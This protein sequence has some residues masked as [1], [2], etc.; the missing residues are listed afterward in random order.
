VAFHGKSVLVAAFA[1]VAGVGV[2]PDAEPA[3]RQFDRG[4]AVGELPRS[5]SAP[6]MRAHLLALQRIADR[7]GGTRAAGTAGYRASVRYVRDRLRA[8]GYR[9]RVVDFP[10]VEY[11][12]LRERVLQIS[13]TS[14]VLRA[15]AIDYSP[16]TPRGGLRGRVVPITRDGCDPTDFQGV[17]GSVALAQR[18]TCFISVKARNAAA[19]GARALIV[20]SA[21]PGPLDA[22]L[23]DPRA[24]SIPVAAVHAA[25]AKRL[26][27]G[28]NAVVRLEITTRR[29]QSTSQ[30]VIAETDSSARR[31]LLVGAHLDSVV[32][33][34][35]INDNGTGVAALLEIARLVRRIAPELSVR[36]GFWGAEEFGLFGSRAYAARVDARELVGYLNLDMLGSRSRELAV[37][38]NGP[39]TE[40]LLEYVRAAGVRATTIDLE[41]RSDHFAF[42]QIGVPT[43]GVM[44]G[45]DRCYHA[46]CDRLGRVDL[47]TLK[48]LA[49]AVA[50]ATASFAPAGA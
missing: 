2:L 12:E 29:K 46:A 41:G 50:F 5:V 40:R 20:Y 1:A 3:G 35:G 26:A 18:G 14:G 31:V 16:S 19:A 32:A 6:R 39:Y 27:G 33:G 4:E 42:D 13:P 8:A 24:S 36:F 9:P 49:R 28:P 23:G 43:G 37:Y 34:P 15:E 10:F 47:E 11:R 7:S 17:R 25:A 22:T 48:T 44:A 38:A 30:N 21:E 45:L